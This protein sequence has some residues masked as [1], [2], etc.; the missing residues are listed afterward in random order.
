[1]NLTDRQDL[2]LKAGLELDWPTGRR[3]AASTKLK[4]VS[5]CSERCRQQHAPTPLPATG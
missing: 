5:A 1:M 4:P 3:T 2:L